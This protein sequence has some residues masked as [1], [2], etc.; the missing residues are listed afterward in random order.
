MDF[1][2]LEPQEPSTQSSAQEEVVIDEI[3]FLGEA[4]DPLNEAILSRIEAGDLFEEN[5][6]DSDDDSS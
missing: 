6:G 2:L 3:L 5:S 1:S 4:D